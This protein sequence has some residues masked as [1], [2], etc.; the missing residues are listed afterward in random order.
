MDGAASIRRLIRF[1]ENRITN[2]KIEVLP[3]FLELS[4]QEQDRAISRS[5]RRKII[6]STNIA[7]T[8]LTIEG[9][10][11]V[12][13]TGLAKKFSYDPY[14]G[15]NV[16][17]SQNISRS[18][19]KQEAG[20]AGRTSN[21]KCIRLWTQSEHHSRIEFE[22]PEIK[23]LDITEIYLNVIGFLPE[24]LV[25]LEEP[26]VILSFNQGSNSL[27]WS[28]INKAGDHEIE[29]PFTYSPALSLALFLSLKE[30]CLST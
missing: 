12:I 20:R 19:A 29:S 26:P 28:L 23:R 25:W 18:S 6:V 15:V 5:P 17:L 27:A 4:L 24:N 16:L 11:V 13:D 22:E 7:E 2:K 14:R 9:I 21:G 10:G 30:G 1:I 3:C 8:S